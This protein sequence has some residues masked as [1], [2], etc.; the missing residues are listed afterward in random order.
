MLLPNHMLRPLFRID[1]VVTAFAGL[2][3]VALP[4]A[5]INLFQLGS[6]SAMWVRVIG[7]VWLLFGLWLLTLWNADYSKGMALFAFV[8]LEI[9]GLL[10]VA[11]A[12]FGGFGLG[13]LGWI[14]LLGTAVFIFFVASQWWFLRPQLA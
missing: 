5:L 1:G 11:A 7:V 9:N 4:T 14:A 2:L 6:M 3:M 13:V 12:I 8:L 10:L